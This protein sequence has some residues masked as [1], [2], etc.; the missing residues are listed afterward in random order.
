[1]TLKEIMK[2]WMDRYRK[3]GFKIKKT[4]DGWVMISPWRKWGR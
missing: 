1:M 3:I 2:E 4:K